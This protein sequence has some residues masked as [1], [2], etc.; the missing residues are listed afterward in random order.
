M[1]HIIS[2]QSVSIMFKNVSFINNTGI[3]NLLDIL[4]SLLQ[5]G[6]EIKFVNVRETVKN[7]FKALGLECI[8]NCS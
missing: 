1:M 7:K 3:A 5:Q 8:F 6:I 2:L 4:K